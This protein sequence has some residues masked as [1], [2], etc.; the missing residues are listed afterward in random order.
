MLLAGLWTMLASPAIFLG[1][2]VVFMVI[3]GFVLVK[4][5]CDSN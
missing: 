3:A 4:L 1:L 2:L 5:G